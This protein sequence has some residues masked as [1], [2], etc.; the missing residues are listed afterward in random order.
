MLP[1]VGPCASTAGR[2]PSRTY[3]QVLGIS[4]DEQ[5]PQVIEEAALRCSA[6]V[7]TYQL[8]R[9]SECAPRLNEIAQALITL[10]DPVR[11][12]DYDLS[13]GKPPKRLPLGRPDTSVLPQGKD[14]LSSPDEGTLQV[15]PGA[16]GA[17]DVKLVYRQAVVAG[18][19][20]G[21]LPTEDTMKDRISNDPKGAGVKRPLVDNLEQP[22]DWYFV[23]IS[24]VQEMAV[25]IE[26]V[27]TV[28]AE[29]GYRP[30][31]IFRARIAIAEAICNAL[32]HGH[33]HDPTMVVEIRYRIRADHLLV[34]VEDQG[35]G[36]DPSQVPDATSPENLERPCG[37]GLLLI[38][39]YAAWVCHN[40]TGN[41]ITFCIC[42][43]VP[44]PAR[45]APE[46]PANC[47]ESN[48]P[49]PGNN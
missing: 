43:S 33:R 13:L 14:A 35:P 8:T 39:H 47:S 40:P 18:T 15:V 3:Y 12:R 38:R 10:L 31:D 29:Q 26:A 36:F 34:Q 19:G 28:M 48:S 5:D 30:K 7:R 9:E 44:L 6:H 21:T 20:R 25:V 24:S 45:Q 37:R 22:D 1:C 41:C 27:A 11:R 2:P 42:P 23:G 49:I 16:G 4:P 17:C 32:K 46:I